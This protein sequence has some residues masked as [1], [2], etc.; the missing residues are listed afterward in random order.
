MINWLLRIKVSNLIL[1]KLIIDIENH[2]IIL[3]KMSSKIW[4]NLQKTR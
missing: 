4:S 2:Y 3:W 1:T